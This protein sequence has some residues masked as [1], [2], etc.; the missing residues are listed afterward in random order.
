M[1]R[2][3]LYLSLMF[4]LTLSACTQVEDK[5][6]IDPSIINNPISADGKVDKNK[7]PKIEFEKIVHD[8]GDMKQG[9]KVSYNFRF[10]NVGK[11]PLY[12]SHASA[13]CGCT[14]PK[15]PTKPIMPGESDYIEVT[16][17]STNKGGK[18]EK[19]VT[20]LA[21]TIPAEN[22]I[23]ITANITGTN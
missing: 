15:F 17:D 21:N 6:T 9:E 10:K 2:I 12:I 23:S 7:L 19:V 18:V 20:I 3:A 14:V 22:N 4:I 11:G 1:K 16:F 13:S 8:F 5:G